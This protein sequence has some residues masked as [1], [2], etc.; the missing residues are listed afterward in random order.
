M[1]GSFYT[2]EYRQSTLDRV[3]AALKADERILGVLIVGSGAIGFDD[4]YSDIDLCI[5]CPDDQTLT[6]YQDWQSRFEKLLP[7]IGCSPVTYGPNS[8]L[9]ALLLDGFLELDAG[10]IGIG[11]LTAK[12]ERWKVAFDRS[13]KIADIM[14]QTWESRPPTDLK[15]EY[16]RRVEGIWHHVLHVGQ[17]LIRRQPWK[18]LHYL[19]TIRNRTLE[20]AGLRLGLGIDHFR[21]IDKLPNDLL[22]DIRQTIPTGITEAE[23]LH[24]LERAVDCF[25]CEASVW[26]KMLDLDNADIL[27]P[28]MYQFLDLLKGEYDAET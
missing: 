21:E 1:S 15:W 19:E 23:I 25:F 26:D 5:V 9:Y 3:L 8:H 7:V 12:R 20:L 16:L 17:A 10:F 22:S 18:A 24:A 6:I 28:R 2:P 11:S 4:E 27:K 14:T 13:G